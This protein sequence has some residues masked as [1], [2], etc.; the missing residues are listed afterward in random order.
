MN[1]GTTAL[2]LRTDQVG[3]FTAYLLLNL[4]PSRPPATYVI[5]AA[6]G[7]EFASGH[8]ARLFDGAIPSRI[9]FLGCQGGPFPGGGD[10]ATIVQTIATLSTDRSTYRIVQTELAHGPNAGRPQLIVVAQHTRTAPAE[11]FDPN[12]IA[13]GA[14]CVGP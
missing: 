9:A 11:G 8:A 2:I 12:S 1:D 5:T 14:P 10:M 6:G 13:V 3:S 7:Q 4:A